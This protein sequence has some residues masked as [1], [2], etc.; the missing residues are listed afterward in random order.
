M[1]IRAHDPLSVCLR[2]F[3]FGSL[4][5]SIFL[6]LTDFSPGINLFFIINVTEG[7]VVWENDDSK[8]RALSLLQT[9]LISFRH[10]SVSQALTQTC[11]PVCSHIKPPDSARLPADAAA[12]LTDALILFYKRSSNEACEAPLE[13]VDNS[14]AHVRGPS[15]PHQTQAC[16]RVAI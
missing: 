1:F 4:C 12:A 5:D 16:R 9:S 2:S 10:L 14:W 7:K 8:S 6:F 11:S 3:S 15:F 13:S